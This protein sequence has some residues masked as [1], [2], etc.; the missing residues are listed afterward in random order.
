MTNEYAMITNLLF[1][2]LL[3]LSSLRSFG[4]DKLIFFREAGSG[5]NVTS[6]FLSQLTLDQVLFSVQAL[7]AAIAS[8]ELRTSLVPLSSWI[9]LYQLTAFF[10][11][12]WAYVFSLVIPRDNLVMFSAL[13]VSVCG[14]LLSGSLTF[15]RYT[16]IY[17]S[18]FLSVFVGMLSSTRW[19][20]EWMIVSEFRALPQ[21]YGFTSEKLDY[22]RIAGYGMGDLDRARLQDGGGWY[23]NVVP[24]VAVGVGLRLVCYSLILTRSRKKMNRSSLGEVARSGVGG[25]LWAF[26]FGVLLLFI[27]FGAPAYVI[28]SYAKGINVLF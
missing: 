18:G 10:C 7:W 22:F 1:V 15:L 6:F 3:T 26:V 28:H 14:T 23:Y 19:F 4:D 9:I 2:I 21:Q 27:G 20:T 12:G 25:L 24:M 16:D 13:F 17:S 11:S 5:F 8:Y